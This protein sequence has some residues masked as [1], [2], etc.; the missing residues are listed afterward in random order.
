MAPRPSSPFSRSVTKLTHRAMARAQTLRP[1]AVDGLEHHVQGVEAGGPEPFGVRR[2]GAWFDDNLG[3]VEFVHPHPAR[4]ARHRLLHLQH[5]ERND[6]RPCPVGHLRQVD[7]E[8]ARQQDQLDWHGRD[9]RPRSGAVE[10]QLDTGEDIGCRRAAMGQD[11]LARAGQVRGVNIVADHLQGEV[12]FDSGADIEGPAMEQRPAA[13]VALDAGQIGPDLPL[14]FEVIRLAQIVLQQH[15][16]GRDGGVG[17][18]LEHPMAIRPLELEQGLL[19][20]LDRV[21]ERVGCRNRLGRGAVENQAH[22]YSSITR[23]TI[24]EVGRG[25]SRRPEIPTSAPPR[26]WPAGRCRSSRRR[27]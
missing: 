23:A 22:Q 10:G 17:L 11:R 14:Q 18:K 2:L 3:L 5:Q 13:V 9:R 21:V 20:P 1:E 4:I 7:R 15:I 6:H 26:S 8:S 25:P 24:G 12:G 16:F 19:G 27:E